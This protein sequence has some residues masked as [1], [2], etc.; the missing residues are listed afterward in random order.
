MRRLQELERE[1]NTASTAVEQ[2][3]N[4]TQKLE[5]QTNLENGKH[6]ENGALAAMQQTIA[7]LSNQIEA[8]DHQIQNQANEIERLHDPFA[9]PAAPPAHTRN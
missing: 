8:K 9:R 4:E 6:E 5:P 2:I 1:G 7:L 3:E